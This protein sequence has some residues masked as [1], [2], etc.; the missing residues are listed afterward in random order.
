M[1]N[2]TPFNSS[3]VSVP[4]PDLEERRERAKAFATGAQAVAS[5]VSAGAAMASAGAAQVSAVAAVTTSQTGVIGVTTELGH[6]NL[7]TAKGFMD[8]GDRFRESNPQRADEYYDKASQ[9]MMETGRQGSNL[10]IVVERSGIGQL[11]VQNL[12]N[13]LKPFD[14]TMMPTAPPRAIRQRNCRD[15]ANCKRGDSCTFGHPERK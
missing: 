9:L 1:A 10:A 14:I 2:F 15:G 12:Q 5:Q 8:L 13:S 3:L 7:S 6:L 4:R 11:A